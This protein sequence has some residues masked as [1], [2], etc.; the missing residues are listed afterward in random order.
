MREQPF[1]TLIGTDASGRI[2]LTQVPVMIDERD[3]KIILTG[4]I[5]KKSDHHRAFEENSQVLA[6]FTSPHVYV[7]GSWYDNPHQGSTWNYISIHARGTIRFLEESGLIGLLKRLSLHFEKGEKSSTTVYDNLPDEY[8]QK[9]IKA[10]HA[11]EIEVTELENVFKL[12]Q[13]RDEKSYN[14][15]IQKLVESGGDGLYIANRMRDNAP[16]IFKQE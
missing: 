6:L 9:L 10:I 14:N 3:E 1:I 7:S 13:N 12:S 4:H 5:A 16:N 15:I 8:T 11:F 2:E